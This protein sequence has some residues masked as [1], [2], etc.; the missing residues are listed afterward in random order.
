M[1]LADALDGAQVPSKSATLGKIADLLERNGIDVDDVGRVQR[2][3][4]WQMG[5]VDKDGDAQAVDLVGVQ[6]SPAWAEGPEWPVV[7][8]AAPVVAKPRPAPSPPS[9]EPRP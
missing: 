6:L 7:A 8:Q 1:G 9:A 2:M 4:L 3:N 5:Y